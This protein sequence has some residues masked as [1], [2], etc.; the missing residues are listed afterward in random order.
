MEVCFHLAE[1]LPHAVRVQKAWK[2]CFQT[3]RIY[4]TG[5]RT[6]LAADQLSRSEGQVG[7]PCADACC[8]LGRDIT[9]ECSLGSVLASSK[10]STRHLLGELIDLTG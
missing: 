2:L 4:V 7:R 8:A 9:C 3:F 6:S 5:L 1:W 10:S